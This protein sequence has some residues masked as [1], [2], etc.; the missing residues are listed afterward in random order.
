[1]SSFIWSAAGNLKG[2]A[3]I[4]VVVVGLRGV[5]AFGSGGVA[6]LTLCVLLAARLF[7]ESLPPL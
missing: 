6:L 2:N 3:S 7:V 5:P 4:T 1:M